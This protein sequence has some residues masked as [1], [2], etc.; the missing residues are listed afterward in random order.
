MNSEQRL[1]A[2]I[3]A[4]EMERAESA[5][6]SQW[7]ELGGETHFWFQWR[8]A[9]FL[10]QLAC[11]PVSVDR[12]LR[13]LDIGCG[14]G[15]LRRQLERHTA[16]QIDGTDLNADILQYQ[17]GF[18]GD[19]LLYDILE[20]RPDLCEAYDGLFLFDVIEHI[21]DTSTF[22][23]AALYHLKPKGW[24]FINVPAIEPLYSVYDAVAG[25]IRRYDKDL[26][27][28]TVADQ[29]AEVKDMRYW[30]LSM[31]P[32]LIARKLVLQVKK[33][34]AAATLQTGFQ[35]KFAFI[36]NLFRI[37]MRIETTILTNPFVGTSLIAAVQKSDH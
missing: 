6:P 25:H 15:I 11:L 14:H 17:S 18:R 28:R 32:I 22:L 29:P 26:L 30:G 4:A 20:K 36:N 33:M 7:Y 1:S 27:L 19:T 23:D 16:W 8:L 9:V 21:A 34:D 31:V 5:F 2:G 12:P 24:L 35:P 10:N 37:M 13:C 3:R